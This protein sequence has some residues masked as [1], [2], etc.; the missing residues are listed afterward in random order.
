MRDYDK[1]VLG[2]P[3]RWREGSWKDVAKQEEENSG[4]EDEVADEQLDEKC[5]VTGKA[6]EEVFGCGVEMGVREGT[7]A[8]E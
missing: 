4:K 3:E 1:R 2:V 8:A 5:S 7:E 6:V